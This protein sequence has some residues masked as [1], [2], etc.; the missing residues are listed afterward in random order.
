MRRKMGAAVV[1]CAVGM[2]ALP[3]GL[4]AQEWT[5]FRGPNGTGISAA[6][7]VPL[8][9]RETDINWRVALPGEGHSSPVVW[10]KRLFL[11]SAEERLGKRHVLCLNTADGKTLW[12]RSYDFKRYGRHAYNS[13]ASATPVVD[14]ERV[15]VLW[16]ASDSYVIAALDHRGNEVWKRDLGGYA[17]QHGGAASP[18]LVGDTLIVSKEPEEEEG[19]LVG[20]DRKTGAIRWKRPRYSKNAAY[21]TPLLY[22]AKDGLPE[23]IF[24]STSHGLTGLDPRSGQVAWEISGLFQARCV[25]SPVLLPNGLIFATAG[26]GAGDR[27]AVAVRPASKKERRAAEIAYSISRGASYVPTPIVVGDRMYLWGDGGVV[28]CIE[29]A[30][31][32]QVWM[33]RVGGNYFGSPICINGK[34]CAMNTKGELVTIAASDTFQILGRNDLGELSHATPSVAN[35]V[36]YLRTQSH[37][38]SVG[39]KQ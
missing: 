30:S 14:A 5:R 34:L 33:E 28:T 12:S 35:G 9:F 24:S 10:G 32:R 21:S 20:L 6:K 17:A 4:R 16:P 13:P 22:Q 36:L 2:L 1:G 39:G 3:M 15:Y 7:T 25:G 38:L 37:L 11:T 26:N 31:G 18:I 8:P 27:Q 19:V 29:A 23:V